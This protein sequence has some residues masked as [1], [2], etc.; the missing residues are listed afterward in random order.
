MKRL[1]RATQQSK[2]LRFAM[3]IAAIALTNIAARFDGPTAGI[4][5]LG[6]GLLIGMLSTTV[7]P[8]P[9]RAALAVIQAIKPKLTAEQLQILREAVTHE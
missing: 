2:S 3:A 7:A 1:Y 6:G 4:A 5:A 9:T 8:R